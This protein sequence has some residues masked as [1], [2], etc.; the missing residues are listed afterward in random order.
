VEALKWFAETHS[1]QRPRQLSVEEESMRVDSGRQKIEPIEPAR[2]GDGKV[3]ANAAGLAGAE[4]G[5]ILA[6]ARVLAN[7]PPEVLRM[8]K[9][10]G[11]LHWGSFNLAPVDSVAAALQDRRSLA[12]ECIQKTGIARLI[13]PADRLPWIARHI[14]IFRVAVGAAFLVELRLEYIQQ[15]NLLSAR[16]D[17]LPDC[18]T[19][20][21]LPPNQPNPFLC[22][23]AY[24]SHTAILMLVGVSETKDPIDPGRVCAASGM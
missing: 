6:F 24:S 22:D 3:V 14:C 12:Y 2:V 8:N 19:P 11:F 21:Y 1:E 23:K 20:G 13:K 7:P 10:K 9:F 17:C 5:A 16:K 15:C 4:E 18:E